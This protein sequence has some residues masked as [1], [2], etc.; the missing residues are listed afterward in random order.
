MVQDLGI[1]YCKMKSSWGDDWLNKN[2]THSFG[3][4]QYIIYPS[5]FEFENIL[6]NILFSEDLRPE[7]SRLWSMSSLSLESRA[8]CLCFHLLIHL[9]IANS[10]P[11][12]FSSLPLS[13][14][15]KKSWIFNSVQCKLQRWYLWCSFIRS[16]RWCCTFANWS[17]QLRRMQLW[18]FISLLHHPANPGHCILVVQ[19]N[20]DEIANMFQN[21]GKLRTQ[22]SQNVT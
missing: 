12:F 16:W 19:K 6:L 21:I 10:F 22:R 5:A 9:R 1:K 13:T 8:Y 17:G 11:F 3:P 4:W 18:W 15:S 2:T 20:I 14:E 7:M